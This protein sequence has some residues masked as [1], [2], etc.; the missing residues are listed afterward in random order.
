MFV[1]LGQFY[2]FVLLLICLMINVAFF[3]EVREPFL[4]DEDPMASVKSAFSEL[5][6]QERIDE[7]YPKMLSNADGVPAVVP[8]KEQRQQSSAS[9]VVDVN[10]VSAPPQ[11]TEP[12][13]RE[14]PKEIS[15]SSPPIVVP[16]K[17]L[18]TAVA[19]PG[20]Q[21]GIIQP[22]TAEKFK[23]IVI[24]RKPIASVKPS[25][26]PVWETIDVFL[27]QPIRRD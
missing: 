27:E 5:D 10:S 13:K 23:P 7:F 14:I 24:E 3:P 16:A 26:V 1:R 11:K 2:A 25:S 9:P 15:K 21:P 19:V 17:N 12:A 8:P 22:A 18:Q 6:I 4:G 20:P